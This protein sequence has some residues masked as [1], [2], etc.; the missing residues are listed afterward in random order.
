M[1]NEEPNRTDAIC[2]IAGRHVYAL[3]FGSGVVKVGQTGSPNTRIAQH[4]QTAQAHGQNISRTWVSPAHMNWQ[5]NEQHLISFCAERWECAAGR[6]YFA[7]A[8]F[9]Q[10]A[11]FAQGLVFVAPTPEDEESAEASA[12]S[13]SELRAMLLDREEEVGAGLRRPW[14]ELSQDEQDAIAAMFGGGLLIPRSPVELDG[15]GRTAL[16]GGAL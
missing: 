10:V 2:G 12:L 5:A 7:Q 13:D 9:D 15:V 1:T 6:E 3:Q 16:E 4:A 14:S 8:D 11:A